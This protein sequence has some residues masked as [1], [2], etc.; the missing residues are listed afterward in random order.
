MIVHV[1]APGLFAGAEQVV[2]GGVRALAESGA[3]VQ[4]VAIRE[5]R[6]PRFADVF[7][8][9]ARALGLRV[10]TITS[11]GRVDLSLA[12]QLRERVADARVL[13]AHGYKATLVAQ[14]ARSGR[15]ACVVTHHGTTSSTW[16]VRAYQA[17]LYRAYRRADAVIAVSAVTR[18]LLMRR[19]VPGAT[20]VVIPNFLSR[21]PSRVRPP[22]VWPVGGP[23]RLLF[24][25]RLSPEKGLSM[26][27]DALAASSA[28]DRFRLRIV[29]EGPERSALEARSSELALRPH[30]TFVGYLDDVGPELAAA[31]VLVLPSEREGLPMTL[32][33]ALAAGIPVVASAVGGIPEV[34]RDRH[35]G[36]LVAPDDTDAWTR[37]LDA[38]PVRVPALAEQAA[39]GAPSVQARFAP[40]RWAEQTRALYDR[41][42]PPAPRTR[43]SAARQSAASGGR[44]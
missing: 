18:E 31:D 10:D 43:F 19:G 42:A 33:E 34:L 16:K 24:L 14:A 11:R 2:V 7:V 28:L 1:I 13:H 22:R 17:L 41:L 15:T 26:F 29:G 44:T 9:R 35:D 20:S 12:A 25:G 21:A 4:I 6:R 40:A 32:L 5:L 8:E 27:L 36:L 3:D 30:V 23:I 38:L 39:R 37:T